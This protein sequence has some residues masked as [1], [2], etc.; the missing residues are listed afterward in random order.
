MFG[1]LAFSFV[2]WTCVD[3]VP[4]G[5]VIGSSGHTRFKDTQST[6]LDILEWRGIKGGS[7]EL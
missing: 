7:N 6:I 1:F 5:P 3:G 2:W 4:M